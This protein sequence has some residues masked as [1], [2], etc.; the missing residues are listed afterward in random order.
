MAS[1]DRIL[2]NEIRDACEK[3]GPLVHG[4]ADDELVQVSQGQANGRCWDGFGP[5]CGCRCRALTGQ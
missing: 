2:L 5:L 4:G 3:R 1:S